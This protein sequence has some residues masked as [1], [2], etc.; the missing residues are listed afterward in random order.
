MVNLESVVSL[1]IIFG[2]IE[3]LGFPVEVGKVEF[4]V[5][6]VLQRLL[7]HLACVLVLLVV[8]ELEGVEVRATLV[9]AHDFGTLAVEPF[10]GF[11]GFGIILG[12][13]VNSCQIGGCLFA[14]G[15]VGIAFHIILK[16]GDGVVKRRT[17]R[18]V[19]KLGVVVVGIL[20]DVG[21]EVHLRGFEEALG[22]E[23]RLSRLDLAVADDVVGALGHGIVLL[24]RFRQVIDGGLVL[25][26]AVLCE[27]DGVAVAGG[28]FDAGTALGL[29]VQR[30]KVLKVAVGLIV[31][32]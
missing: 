23:A 4:C 16:G 29:L 8:D 18:F 7:Q 19:L 14:A 12:G 2:T 20:L 9:R 15:G 13:S 6:R 25:L 17:G 5:H 3:R 27:P 26:L 1:R 28:E 30:Q 31:I 21:V 10:D 24:R 11:D 22:S 32:P